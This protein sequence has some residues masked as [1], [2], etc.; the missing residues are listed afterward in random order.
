MPPTTLP[1]FPLPIVL[2]PGAAQPLHV[3]EPR[4]R[5]LLRD[6][7]EGDSIFGLSYAHQPDS[8][9]PQPG[10]VGCSA[11]IEKVRHMPDGRSN[12]LAVGDKRY[13]LSTL[14]E[15]DSPYLVGEVEFFEDS[16]GDAPGLA[17]LAAEVRSGF[18][19]FVRAVQEISQQTGTV[20]TPADPIALSFHLA[21]VL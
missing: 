4:Y 9:I 17:D 16:D 12:L 5:A 19:K 14:I 21:A 1:L 7:L 18:E 15:A 6:C 3:F 20:E 10:D 2:F 11:R 8:L 13:V